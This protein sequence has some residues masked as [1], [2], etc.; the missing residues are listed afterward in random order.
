MSERKRGCE[1]HKPHSQ[2]GCMNCAAAASELAAPAGCASDERDALESWMR[3][4]TDLLCYQPEIPMAHKQTM[5]D[6]F[7]KYRKAIGR[8]LRP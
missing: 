5:V 3:E 4:V 8:P 2:R 7:A 1:A 6:A